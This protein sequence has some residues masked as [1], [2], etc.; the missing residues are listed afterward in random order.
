M[1]SR[2]PLAAMVAW[3]LALPSA[4]HAQCCFYPEDRVRGVRPLETRT[5][6]E[7]RALVR[8]LEQQHDAAR[9]AAEQAD[10]Q[11]MMTLDT[12]REGVLTVLA[13]PNL[14]PAVREAARNLS[15]LV[16]RTYGDAAARLRNDDSI[17]RELVF[18]SRTGGLRGSRDSAITAGVAR[19]ALVIA[20]QNVMRLDWPKHPLSFWYGSHLIAPYSAEE[21]NQGLEQTFIHLVTSRWPAPQRCFA[22]DVV[23]CRVALALATA[24][25]PGILL[26]QV[27][28]PLTEAQRALFGSERILPGVNRLTFVRFTLQQGGPGAYARFAVPQGTMGDALARAAE[29]P[30]DTLIAHW[31][32][33]VVAAAPKRV[34]TPFA[35]AWA[36][37]AWVVA[38]GALSLRSGRWHRV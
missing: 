33:S 10:R 18:H 1:S 38:F 9:A 8:A 24:D 31:R 37:V 29:L 11:R 27:G 3:G 14:V 35:V 28:Q 22:G 2:W 17:S 13:A 20:V 12:V 19:N 5:V 16:E 30:L 15:P 23:Q 26:Y 4:G 25:A 36:A 7:L 6:P 32:T 34:T 21:L